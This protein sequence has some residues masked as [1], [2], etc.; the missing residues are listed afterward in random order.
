[1]KDF[2]QKT[3]KPSVLVADVG[4]KKVN[5]LF[6]GILMTLAA[7]LFFGAI[8]SIMLNAYNGGITVL[9]MLSLKYLLVTAILVPYSIVKFEIHKLSKKLILNIILVSGILYVAQSALYAYAVTLMPIALAAML[10]FTYPI[11][12]SAISILNGSEK[13]NAK[14]FALLL[15]SFA[16]LVFMFS[17]G[18]H[19]TSLLGVVC[20]LLAA[21]SYAVYVVVISG[22]TKEL[23]PLVTN[24]IVNAGSAVSIT[25][26][27]VVSGSF[28]FD[29]IPSTWWYILI[30]ALFA[31]IIAYI[32]WFAG[33]KILGAVKTSV[34]SMTEPVFASLISFFMLGQKM[35]ICEIFGGLVLLCSV[36]IFMYSKSKNNSV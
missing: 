1:M 8:P 5:R 23:T 29:F 6:K 27:A 3:T 10:L 11:M 36:T 4:S 34:I 21:L 28:S 35:S 15:V 12:V 31:G 30:N 19:G 32:L 16:G 26:L 20:T 24:T 13:F 2:R 25:L 18:I 22:L 33:L 9:T 14:S 7:S 17:G